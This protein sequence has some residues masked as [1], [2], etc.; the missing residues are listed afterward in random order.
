[1]SRN[2]S[3]TYFADIVS[4]DQL[5]VVEPYVEH[6]RIFVN[7]PVTKTQIPIFI[8]SIYFFQQYTHSICLDS[9]PIHVHEIELFNIYPCGLINLPLTVKKLIIRSDLTMD[10]IDYSQIAPTIEEI[11]LEFIT[12]PIIFTQNIKKVIIKDGF[13]DMIDQCTFPE[14]CF[15]VDNSNFSLIDI[16]V[17]DEIQKSLK[18]SLSIGNWTIKKKPVGTAQMLQRL[19]NFK[20]K[21]F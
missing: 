1:M 16:D 6:I 8:T 2:C 11:E 13:R 10:K 15:V 12:K 18:Y 7:E 14:N 17:P 20:N 19:A 4:I 21:Q 9:L 5:D 3:K